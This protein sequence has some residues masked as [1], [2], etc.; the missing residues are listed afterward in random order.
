MNLY[1]SDRLEQIRSK[2]DMSFRVMPRV[3]NEALFNV[4]PDGSDV[5]IDLSGLLGNG[6]LELEERLSTEVELALL[7]QFAQAVDQGEAETMVAAVC[8]GHGFVSDDR[9]ALKVLLAHTTSVPIITTVGLMRRWASA[10][11][12]NP[13]DLK[14]TLRKI[15]VG[16]NFLPSRK[17]PDAV[18]WQSIT[19]V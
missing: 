16:G 8:R 17:D 12:P 4:G 18:W 9:K 6:V 7:M 15:E 13:D 2:L 5:P 1:A 11:N 3:S 10:S 19:Q 14:A